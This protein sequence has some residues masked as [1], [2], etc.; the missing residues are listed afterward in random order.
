MRN[1]KFDSPKQ[2]AEWLADKA[3]GLSMDDEAAEA[4]S[5]IL[6]PNDY[7]APSAFYQ[8]EKKDL[9][10]DGLSNALAGQ[11]MYGQ[12]VWSKR[13][14]EELQE[15]SA[16][17]KAKLVPTLV[18]FG[19][20]KFYSP[21]EVPLPEI[22]EK[23][24][25]MPFLAKPGWL[26]VSCTEVLKQ[27]DLVDSDNPR[28][29]PI[30]LVRCSRGGKTRSIKEIVKKVR[31]T[32]EDY[33]LVFVTFNSETPLAKPMYHDPIGELCV[34][35]AYAALKEKGEGGFREFYSSNEVGKEWVEKWLQSPKGQPMKKC[36]LFVDE[37]NLVLDK[38]DD[39]LA[40]F[41]KENF[42]CPEERG[43][44][45]T[46]HVASTNTRLAEFMS[47]PGNREVILRPLPTIPSLFE[48]R[49]AF[50][51][52]DLSAQEALYFGMIPGLILEK[53]LNH[54]IKE[55][56]AQKL[57]GYIDSLHEMGQDQAVL[58]LSNLL[59]TLLTGHPFDPFQELM[60]ADLNLQGDIVL[61]WIPFH[62]VEV[63]SAISNKYIFLPESIRGCLKG[64]VALLGTFR[65]A[66]KE[67][68]DAW[69]AL[70]LI[71]L[72]IR[73]ITRQFLQEVVPLVALPREVEVWYNGPYTPNGDF[74]STDPRR[75]LAGI[76][77]DEKKKIGI[78]YPPHARFNTYDV[79]LAYWDGGGARF[80]FGYQLKEGKNIS[81][82]YAMD[83]HFDGSYLIKGEAP[84]NSSTSKLWQVVK[85]QDLETYF[86]ESA[87]QWSP[88]NWKRL[89][90]QEEAA[91]EAR[92]SSS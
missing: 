39:G 53:K 15:G 27:A 65:T 20:D 70:F 60:T 44:V 59:L 56:R 41:L 81:N 37:L 75:F 63:L 86:G 1:I 17:K 79:I 91:D 85:K 18:D 33:G 36:I 4:V 71:V 13:V 38:A 16:T 72:I 88:Q 28:V 12:A 90:D 64:I 62:M 67:S 26:D 78:Y 29:S 6:H 92:G 49:N 89:Q 10:E 25:V 73:C 46:S 32:R 84:A 22:T 2:L 8:V 50:R 14:Q 83:K 34:R 58:S 76:P 43:L 69:E 61:R 57:H 55:R 77:M 19:P 23:V 7:K 54:E 82:S 66:K 42:V 48:T 35:I 80:L 87:A 74:F 21:L 11:V 68:G 9:K 47:S 31:E 52:Q 45:F 30:A 40:S 5:A 3:T 24:E 51:M